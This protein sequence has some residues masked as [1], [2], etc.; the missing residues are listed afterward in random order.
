MMQGD[1]EEERKK[2]KKR[3]IFQNFIF[4]SNVA[5][6]FS[7]I[8]KASFMKLFLCTKLN[9]LKSEIKKKYFSKNKK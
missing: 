4:I 7:S 9:K 6:S 2:A 1:R 3:K 5:C 8:H